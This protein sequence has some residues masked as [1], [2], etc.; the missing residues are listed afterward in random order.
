[1]VQWLGLVAFTAVTWVRSLVGELRSRKPRGVAKNKKQNKTKKGCISNNL[2]G[3]EDDVL[4]KTMFEEFKC[5]TVVKT[6]TLKMHVN[7]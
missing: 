5:A 1:M 2:E 6:L 7:A 3:S 4:W